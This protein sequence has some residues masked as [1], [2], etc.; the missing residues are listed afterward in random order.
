MPYLPV[1]F[2]KSLLENNDLNSIICFEWW[3][4]MQYHSS[5]TSLV[6]HI[7]FNTWFM[8]LPLFRICSCHLSYYILPSIK[9][10][11][12]MFFVRTESRNEEGKFVFNGRRLQTYAGEL[13]C[14]V[15]LLC[16]SVEMG[17]ENILLK[18]GTSQL[19][20]AIL[21]ADILVM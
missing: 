17:D 15:T 4:P 18:C 6:A 19:W 11:Y 3:F 7:S 9:F 1:L 13:F 2:W 21:I 12:F 14:I 5:S 16:V 10:C 20:R 8:D